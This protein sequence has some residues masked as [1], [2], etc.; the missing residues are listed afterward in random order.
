MTGYTTAVY[1]L[2]DNQETVKATEILAKEGFTVMPYMFPDLNIARDLVE[3]GAAC[4]AIQ[5]GRVYSRRCQKGTG[6]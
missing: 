5:A 2:P 3:A 4:E 1:F 6:T